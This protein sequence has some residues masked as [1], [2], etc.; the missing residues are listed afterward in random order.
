MSR[1]DDRISLVD[2]LIYA[3]EAVAL[4]GKTNLNDL[5]ENRVMQLA[6]QKLVEIVG[7]AANRISE[8]TQQQYA[9]IPWSQ[10]IGLRNRLVHGYDNV[11]LGILWKIIRNDLPPLIEQLKAIVGEKKEIEGTY[12]E[13]CL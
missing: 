13:Q 2:M 3:K 12:H 10:I 8:E 4:S 9:V 7:E 11:D 1:R 6:L 5:V